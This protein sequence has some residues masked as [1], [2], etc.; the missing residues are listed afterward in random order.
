MTSDLAHTP[1]RGNAGNHVAIQTAH[2]TRRRRNPM[3]TRSRR[4][5]ALLIGFVLI[6]TGCASD[7]PLDTLDPAG[8][9]AESIDNLFMG[10]FYV[11]TI[12]FVLVFG[13]VAY[14]AW[15]YRVR[16]PGPDDTHYAGDYPDEEF[17]DQV[18]GNFQLEIGWTIAPTVIMVVVAVFT[19]STWFG[20]DDVE[21]A[22]ETSPYPDMEV[23][24][25]GHQWWWEFQYH[26]DGDTVHAARRRGRERARHPRRPG[27]PDLH[28]LARRDPQLLDPAT[29]RQE[30]LGTRAS[31]SLDDPVERDRPLR[32]P[33]HRVLRA[34][35][36]VHA[37][38]H[39]CR[40][41]TTTSRPGSTTRPPC[42]SR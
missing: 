13:A 8:R 1:A 41:A 35:P 10:V 29:E 23:L 32:R 24:V 22:P 17:P 39:R 31:A 3:R 36:C 38:V 28:H 12:I 5:I 30:G 16:K 27:H 26:L 15:K 7:A 4:L 11:A 6:A 21:A 14:I 40:R 25:V 18:H 2:T 42:A 37:H 33:V 34:L 20:L 19:L 9:K